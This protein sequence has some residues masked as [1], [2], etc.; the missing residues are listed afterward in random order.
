VLHG[1]MDA[2]DDVAM[3]ANGT[4]RTAHRHIIRTADRVIGYGGKVDRHV[5]HDLSR[6]SFILTN[7]KFFASFF[8][9]KKAF[10]PLAFLWQLRAAVPA[11]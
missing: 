9:K 8:S 4:E 2:A 10:L 5:A 3:L 1:G 7:Q 6:F 11:R